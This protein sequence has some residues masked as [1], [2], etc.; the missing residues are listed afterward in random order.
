M[1]TR[2]SMKITFSGTVDDGALRGELTLFEARVTSAR[3]KTYVDV[4]ID[5]KTPVLDYILQVCR[6]YGDFDVEAKTIV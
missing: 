5:T 2:M 4:I 1:S 3:S 6:K